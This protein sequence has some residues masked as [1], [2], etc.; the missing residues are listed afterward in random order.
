MLEL[1]EGFVGAILIAVIC[2]LA[3]MNDITAPS[4]SLEGKSTWIVQSLPVSAWQVLKAKLTLHVILTAIPVFL[5]SLCGVIVLRPTVWTA[6]LIFLLPL[7]YVV[8]SAC[9]GLFLN[10]QRPNLKWTS[11]IIPIKQS[12]SVMVALFGGW[13]YAIAIAVGCLLLRKI[14]PAEIILLAVAVLTV[15][16]VW[17]LYR[18]LRKKGTA[19]FEAL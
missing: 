4:V 17:L 10:L 12:M 8:F 19:I 2:M 6:L 16:L 7:L 15:V 13:G 11:E 5:C 3:S 14:I 1:G 18:W 9:F